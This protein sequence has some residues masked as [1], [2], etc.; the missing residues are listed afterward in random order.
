MIRDNVWHQLIDLADRIKETNDFGGL[1]IVVSGGN[2]EDEHIEWCLEQTD[3][4]LTKEE[5]ELAND[6]LWSQEEIRSF[7]YFLSQNEIILQELKKRYRDGKNE[8][9]SL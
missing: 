7:S 9:T 8:R 2:V 4:P 6:L 5:K 1:H 3:K